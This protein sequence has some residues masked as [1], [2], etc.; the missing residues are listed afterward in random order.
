MDTSRRWTLCTLGCLLLLLFGQTAAYSQDAEAR[1]GQSGGSKPP[2]ATG[3]I[4]GQAGAVSLQK[5]P[6]L[7]P[8]I[9]LGSDK[10]ASVKTVAGWQYAIGTTDVVLPRDGAC[11]VTCNL[12]V[13][14]HVMKGSLVFRTA[15]RNVTEGT[16]EGDDAW[17]MDV[18]VPIAQGSSS[19]TYAWAMKGG[20]VYR[21]GC[22]M[23]PDG[24]FVGI[25]VYPN[26]SWICR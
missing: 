15:R 6:A 13:Q 11:L 14:S 23:L 21:F 9:Q 7:P 5:I 2:S 8:A 4:T 25:P 17:A 3:R 26:V 16:N 1:N 20:Q 22:R 19:T 18:P 12:D 24:S 10:V